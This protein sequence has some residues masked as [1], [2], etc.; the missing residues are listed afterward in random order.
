MK[1]NKNS[2]PKEILNP[3]WQFNSDLKKYKKSTYKKILIIIITWTVFWSIIYVLDAI[4]IQDIIE[5]QGGSDT[6]D[7]LGTTLLIIIGI[8]IFGYIILIIIIFLILFF[9][10]KKI[11]KNSSLLYI[12][13]FDFYLFHLNPSE[14]FFVACAH[15]ARNSGCL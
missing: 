2:S 5:S 1:N 10:I 9:H 8:W 13:S 14:C 7:G 4:R 3:K 11:E 15:E 12:R 6:G